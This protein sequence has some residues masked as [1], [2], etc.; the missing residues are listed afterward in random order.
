MVTASAPPHFNPRPVNVRHR[1]DVNAKLCF[2]SEE[3]CH[4]QFG[5]SCVLMVE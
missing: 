2:D 4:G 1:V 5:A 3:L